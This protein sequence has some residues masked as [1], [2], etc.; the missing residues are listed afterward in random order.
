MLKSFLRKL[1]RKYGKRKVA[2]MAKWTLVVVSLLLAYYAV[3]K[4][5][6][7]VKDLTRREMAYQKVY[8]SGSDIVL[9]S[10]GVPYYID[11]GLFGGSSFTKNFFRHFH[12]AESCTVWTENINATQI[13]G[14]ATANGGVVP[15]Q[16]VK[17]A[18][19]YRR[20]KIWLLGILWLGSIALWVKSS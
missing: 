18:N 2:K 10:Q 11:S 5:D 13:L 9:E 14:F 3:V 12:G 8:L 16:G 20:Y 4:S 7:R 1:Y 15:D 17:Q 19:N 6:L